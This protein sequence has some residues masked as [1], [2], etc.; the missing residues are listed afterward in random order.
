MC[1]PI[2]WILRVVNTVKD[3]LD[4]KNGI[5]TI[6]II[7]LLGGFVGMGFIYSDFKDF[8][9]EQTRN[10]A[11]QTEVLRVIETRLSNLEHQIRQ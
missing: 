8:L 9:T 1:Q 2:E 11:A 3:V 5:L 4:G 6:L 7:V 10:Q